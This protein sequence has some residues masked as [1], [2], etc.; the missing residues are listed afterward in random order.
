MKS[1]VVTIHK[2]YPL[3]YVLTVPCKPVHMTQTRYLSL[4]RN[5]PGCKLLIKH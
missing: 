3:N 4:R 1:T 2:T 5:Q